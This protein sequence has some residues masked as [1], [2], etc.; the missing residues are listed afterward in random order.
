MENKIKN[1][2]SNLAIAKVRFQN[3]TK[4]ATVPK[5]CSIEV[6]NYIKLIK[7]EDAI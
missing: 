4:V 6:G 5:D 7:V 1:I 3:N 2:K